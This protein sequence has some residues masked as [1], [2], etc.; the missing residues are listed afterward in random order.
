MKWTCTHSALRAVVVGRV[1]SVVVLAHVFGWKEPWRMMKAECWQ[2]MRAD[3]W[4]R[5]K[6]PAQL[7]ETRDR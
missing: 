6:A 4:A 3:Y 2:E 1:V 5:T 7:E